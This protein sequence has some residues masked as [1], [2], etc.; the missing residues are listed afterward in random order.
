MRL[1]SS[2]ALAVLV[3]TVLTAQ[4]TVTPTNDLPNPFTT[5]SDPLKLPEGRKWGS[6][7]AVDVDKDG[8][9]IWVAERCA[10]NKCADPTGKMSP[11]NPVLKFDASGKLVKEFGAGMIAFAHGIHVD[12]DGNVWVTDAND[13]R[14]TPARG[15]SAEAPAAA[16]SAPATVGHQ[17]IKF[18]P[19]GRVLLRLGKAGVAGNPPDALTEPNDVV[20]APNGDIFVGEGH[21]GQNQNAT[22]DTIAR[23][24]K[25]DKTGKF[26]KSWGKLGS[27]PG[28]FRTPHSL[29]F[30]SRGRLFVADRGNVRL[31]VFDQDGKFL[32]QTLAFSRLSG[33]YIDKND[34]LYGADSESSPTSHPGNWKRGIRIGSAKDLKVTA[35]IPDPDNPDPAKTTAGTSA[36][37]GVVADSKGTVYGAEVGPKGVKKY[38]KKPGT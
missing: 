11:L 24:S 32:E 20:T 28:E 2:L 37:E 25:F 23:I 16:P 12:R 1:R 30:D 19:D 36:A 8:V 7:S 9:S 21:S 31:Q 13:N 6:T 35:L 38:L 33:I 27:A 5:V 34:V 4:N 29:A 15:R 14:P 26:I 10:E 18:S 3:G 22:P 17:V